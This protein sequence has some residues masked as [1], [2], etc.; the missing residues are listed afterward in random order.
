MAFTASGGSGSFPSVSSFVSNHLFCFSSEHANRAN[1]EDANRVNT[2]LGVPG[3]ESVE[4]S[5]NEMQSGMKNSFSSPWGVCVL[6][7]CFAT[8]EAED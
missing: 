6:S 1:S 5:E 2:Y 8:D 3:E 4:V 7:E